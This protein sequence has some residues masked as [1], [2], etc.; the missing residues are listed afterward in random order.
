MTQLIAYRYKT[1]K[2]YEIQIASDEL[3]GA[4]INYLDNKLIIKF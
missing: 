1:S 3:W 4:H 2:G